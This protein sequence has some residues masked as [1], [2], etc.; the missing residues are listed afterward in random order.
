MKKYKY[1][2]NP[3]AHGS[4]TMAREDWIFIGILVY[5][6]VMAFGIGLAIGF[7]WVYFF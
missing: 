4:Y 6:S 2:I 3:D 5:S 7:L 1:G